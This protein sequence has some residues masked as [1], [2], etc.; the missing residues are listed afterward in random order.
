[1]SAIPIRVITLTGSRS[2]NLHAFEN[3]PASDVG[4][5]LKPVAT[6]HKP[7]SKA[8]SLSS[9][10]GPLGALLSRLGLAPI[11]ETTPA[12]HSI[13]SDRFPDAD[14]WKNLFDEMTLG[15]KG[16]SVPIMEGGVVSILPVMDGAG[17]LDKNV[18][19]KQHDYSGWKASDGK[20]GH[21]LHAHHH[22]HAHGRK[23]CS[24]G[25]R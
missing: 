24:F 19:S 1:M 14:E 15:T 11:H 16:K 23:A 21:K 5:D 25:G 20:E 7:C 6:H 13:M 8:K 2:D 4:L 12:H 17:E 3:L 10:L 9:G 18:E 22:M